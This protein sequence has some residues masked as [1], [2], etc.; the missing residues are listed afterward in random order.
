VNAQIDLAI[1]FKKLLSLEYKIDD[2]LFASGTVKSPDAFIGVDVA[3]IEFKVFKKKK[4]KVLNTYDIKLNSIRNF[5]KWEYDK[6]TYY[7]YNSDWIEKYI[8]FLI[9]PNFFQVQEVDIN[10]NIEVLGFYI[11]MNF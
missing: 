2:E 11:F 10:A 4:S 8:Q 6:A 5:E 3:W 7:A 1:Y 9:K